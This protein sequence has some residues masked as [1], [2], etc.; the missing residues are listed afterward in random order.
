MNSNRKGSIA[1]LAIAHEAGRLGYGVLWPLIEHGRFDLAIELG[2]RIARIQCKWGQLQDEVIR[3][4]L[5]TSRH[6]PLNG[7]IRTKY[8][9]AEV[10]AVGIHCGEL[11]QCF[12]I[13]I[14]EIEGRSTINLRLR[15]ARN[16]QQAAVNFAADYEFPGAVAQLARAIGWQPVG[17]GF[18]S[19]Q[20]HKPVSGVQVIGSNEF[21]AHTAPY[22]ER[23]KAGERF[24]ITRRGRPMAALVPPGRFDA[25]EPADGDLAQ[26]TLL[27][28][29]PGAE[30]A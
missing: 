12:L 20:L 10:D 28:E 24:L 29:P 14:T 11:N 23:A 27:E 3:V 25:I 6:T 16:N 8:T 7:Y 1:E 13:P 4:S 30:A 22:V 17:R 18:E 21:G 26:P 19:L 15:P 5:A 2:T 9:A